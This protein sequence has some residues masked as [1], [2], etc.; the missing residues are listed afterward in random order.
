VKLR[1]AIEIFNLL[2]E[3]YGGNTLSRAHVFEWHKR[4]SEGRE[5]VEANE[6]PGCPVKM[7]IWKR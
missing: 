6:Q 5:D 4:F 2:H 1:T 3:V 7:K